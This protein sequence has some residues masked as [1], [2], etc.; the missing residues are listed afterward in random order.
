MLFDSKGKVFGKVSIVDIAVIV[1]VVL[2]VVGGYF[3]FSGNNTSV[4][5]ND[6]EFYYSITAKG[7][8]E[9]N[10]NLLENSIGT[11]FRLAGKISSSMGELVGVNVS[12]A[13]DIVAKT[14]G[15]IVLAE[16]PEKYDVELILKVVGNVNDSG[17]FTPET[18]EICAAK[19]Y[20]ITNIYCSVSGIVNKV[21]TE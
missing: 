19:K 12:N 2:A 5:S 15:T 21:W 4:V 6:A 3:R 10:K 9:T 1:L 20:D 18:H 7:I 14:D 13:K 8:R 16:V 17:Y 11:D